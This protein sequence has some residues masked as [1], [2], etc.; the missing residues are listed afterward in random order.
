MPQHG[1]SPNWLPAPGGQRSL[2]L[3]IEII[4]GPIG[5]NGNG[6]MIAPQRQ[7][8]HPA[9][10][11][12]LH[13]AER[14]FTARQATAR[15]ASG[16]TLAREP[17]PVTDRL[18]KITT[19]V[20]VTAVAAVAAVISYRHD[21]ELVRSGCLP[22]GGVRTRGDVGFGIRRHPRVRG[23]WVRSRASRGRG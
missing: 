18:I 9:Q 11:H 13:S 7:P 22:I 10:G 19:A 5:P 8:Q 16:P 20:A 2:H 17:D 21:Y 3:Q 23:G 6:R 14:S 1:G 4:D 12:H 15:T